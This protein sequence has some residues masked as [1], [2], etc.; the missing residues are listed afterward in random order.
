MKR[1][2]SV[3]VTFLLLLSLTACGGNFTKVDLKEP[4]AIPESGMIEKRVFD[5]IKNENAIATFTGESGD[6]KYEW[7]V[8]GSDLN[9]TRDVNLS[10]GLEKT[11]KGIKIKFF[12]MEDFGFPALLSVQLNEKWTA[13]SATAYNGKDVVYSVSITGSKTS[14]LNISVNKIV[15]ECEILPDDMILTENAPASDPN[16]NKE[17]SKDNSGTNKTDNYLSGVKDSNDRIYSDG[18][19]KGKDKYETDP[20]PEGKPLPVE[21]ENQEINN[22][23]TYTC[24]FSI[25]C[26]TILNNLK[27]LD[28]DKRELVPSN[29]VILAP[30]KVTFYEGESVFDVLQR[31]CKENGIHMES[32][33]TPVYNSAYIEGIHN[34][35]E[36]D[37]G[38]LSGWMYRVNGW[39]PNYGCSRYQLVDGEV[40][41]WRYTCDLG[42][43]VGREGTW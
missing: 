26:S 32:S 37:C 31:V 30:T 4:I 23:K 27:D 17:T 28:P 24:T 3:I 21:P 6:M 2:I 42:N 12:E 9:H 11:E 33:W 36:F 43:D 10:L 13:S 7:T 38:E 5:K 39:Y 1:I 18:Q 40:V 16:S 25:E 8:F 15:T 29:G 14:I 41:E 19:N 34:L 35:Y 22:K 20:V